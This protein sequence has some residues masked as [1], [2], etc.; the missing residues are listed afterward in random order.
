MLDAGRSLQGNDPDNER[1][2][3]SRSAT[4]DNLRR[5]A[6]LAPGA[7]G[8][9]ARVRYPTWEELRAM[10]PTERRLVLEYFRRLNAPRE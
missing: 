2:R 10:S 8:P 5:P 1:E 6:D 4:G 3:T 7:T 9:G